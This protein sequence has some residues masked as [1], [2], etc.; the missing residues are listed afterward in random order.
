MQQQLQAL[1]SS[2][3]STNAGME[4]RR[5]SDPMLQRLPSLG[6]FD[7]FGDILGDGGLKTNVNSRPLYLDSD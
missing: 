6:A 3:T 2:G 5:V 7:P 1:Y 4:D